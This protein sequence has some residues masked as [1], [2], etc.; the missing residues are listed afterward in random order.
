MVYHGNER[1][2]EYLRHKGALPIRHRWSVAVG[3]DVDIEAAD[4]EF[5]EKFNRS[6]SVGSESK[7]VISAL[8]G[9]ASVNETFS[10][11]TWSKKENVSKGA[12]RVEVLY[13]DDTPVQCEVGGQLK[14]CV[15]KLRVQ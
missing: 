13:D 15:F 3:E 1:T 2:I 4:E 14:P 8:A 12:W 7:E 10:W 6:L 9:Q 11:R 5:V